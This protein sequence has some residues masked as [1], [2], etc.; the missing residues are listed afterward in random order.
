MLQKTEANRRTGSRSGVV[1]MERGVGNH[2]GVTAEWRAG[3]GLTRENGV[4]MKTGPP[5]T[6]LPVPPPTISKM[7]VGTRTIYVETRIIMRTGVY[8]R[9]A[10]I[11]SASFVSTL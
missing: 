9:A 7:T 8:V 1:S 2:H 4:G 6:S 10:L 5:S 11:K 3:A